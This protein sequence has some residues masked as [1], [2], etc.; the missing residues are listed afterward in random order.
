MTSDLLDVVDVE[1]DCAILLSNSSMLVFTMDK[2][3]GHSLFVFW[4]IHLE[5]RVTKLKWYPVHLGVRKIR[6]FKKYILTAIIPFAVMMRKI[7][8]AK[9]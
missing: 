4:S 8:V 6:P 5:K 2:S 1:I 9:Y 3:K 7:N